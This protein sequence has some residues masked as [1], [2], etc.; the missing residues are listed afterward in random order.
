MEVGTDSYLKTT[1]NGRF[2]DLI[3]KTSVRCV[4]LGGTLKG[5]K[6]HIKLSIQKDDV[7]FFRRAFFQEIVVADDTSFGTTDYNGVQVVEV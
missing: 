3:F 7:F 1:K 4:G 5:L 6:R 2:F